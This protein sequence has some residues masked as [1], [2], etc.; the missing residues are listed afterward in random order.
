MLRLIRRYLVAGIMADGVVVE[1]NEGT[2]QGGPL[3]PLLANV[4]VDEVDREL[5][6][7]GLVRAMRTT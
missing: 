7:R 4:L 1:R 6:Q 2:R 3:S 5:E